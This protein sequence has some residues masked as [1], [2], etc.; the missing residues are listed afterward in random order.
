MGALL[1]GHDTDLA[2]TFVLSFSDAGRVLFQ[3]PPKISSDN[4]KGTWE[5]GE[6]RGKEP[7]ATFSTSGPREITIA[8]T[9]IAD[10]SP[11]W[12][13]TKIHQQI[14]AVRGY[15]ARVRMANATRN[16][17]C[18]LQ[19]W[20]IGGPKAISCRITNISVKYGETLVGNSKN[21]FPLRT[22]LTLD[23]RIWTSGATAYEALVKVDG[24]KLLEDP[25]WY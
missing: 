2:S 15:F 1:T 18:T 8:T 9:Y 4:R 12:T 21:A 11:D 25:A 17:V 10:G 22:D 7:F 23:V 6:Q 20:G 13:A 5:E 16:L 3:F 24:L 14:L 19:M